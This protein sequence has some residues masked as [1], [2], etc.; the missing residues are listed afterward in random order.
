VTRR[1]TLLFSAFEA[2]LVAAIGVAIPLLLATLMWAIQFGFAPDWTG[3]WRAAVD[4]WL[5]GHGVDVT[6]VL[7]EVTAATISAPADASLTVTI[8]ALGLGL[9]TLLLGVRAG[10]RV[11]EAG[12]LVL[13]TLTAA[14]VFAGVSLL[15]TASAVHDAARP[16]LWQ[17]VVLPAVVFGIGLMLGVLRADADGGAPVH[18]RIAAWMSAGN[19]LLRASLGAALRAGVASVMFVLLVSSVT[20]A[21]VLATGYAQVIRLYETLHTEVLGGAVLT[22]GQLAMM[23]NIVIWVASWFTGPGFALGVG[24]QVSPLGTTVGPLPAVPVLGAVPVGELS[25]GFAGLV[26]PVVAAFLAA[27][28]V[29]PMF[30]RAV[31]DGSPLL[32]SV[33]V[34]L[35]GGT[36]GGV[37]MGVLA[38]VSAGSAG[39]GRFA[40]VGPDPLAVGLAAALE[41]TIGLALGLAAAFLPAALRRSG[42]GQTL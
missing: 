1:L 15:L 22:V 9:L 4:V 30:T 29:R 26:V 18:G 28:A 17:G 34:A 41:F 24:S 19:P 35:G 12:H 7:D 20:A 36:V 32:V 14:V 3:F 16:V 38:A 33:G 23:P 40:Q 39:P 21:I 13:G 5:I 8:A 25:F 11:A 31:G 2:L 6:F 10:M 37:L 42:E 27:T